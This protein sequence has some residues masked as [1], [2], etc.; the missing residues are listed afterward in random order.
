MYKNINDDQFAIINRNLPSEKEFKKLS[1]DARN[2]LYTLV[3]RYK[4]SKILISTLKSE[5]NFGLKRIELINAI[6]ELIKSN[7]LNKTKENN[8]YTLNI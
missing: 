2:I 6:N 3:I 8:I 5:S 7:Y 4:N 1:S